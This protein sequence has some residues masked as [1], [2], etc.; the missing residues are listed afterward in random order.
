VVQA[1]DFPETKIRF[2][3]DAC[4]QRVGLSDLT[5]DEWIAH[6]G[7]FEPLPDN[8]P[9]PL[10][11][12]YHGHQFRAYN[13]DI[14]DGRGFTFAQLRD[15][16]ERLLDLG[17]KGSGQTPH[18]RFGDGR[19][20]LKGGVREILATEMLEAR[21]V[22]TSKTL[23]VIETGEQLQRN[24]EPSPTRSCVLVRL[25]HAHIRFGSFERHAHEQRPDR[26]RMLADHCIEHY[27]P[28]LEDRNP[29]E[30]YSRWFQ[31]VARRTI[32]LAGSWMIAGFVHGVLN[33]DNM[34]I[35]GESFDYG[36][37][38]FLPTY[39]PMFIAAYF[40]HGGLYAFGRQPEAVL[41][42]LLRFAE[43]IDSLTPVQQSIEWLEAEFDDV[44]TSAVLER[45]CD[46]LGISRGDTTE[47]L[48]LV[49][50]AFSFARDSQVGYD[51]FFFD[52]Y[53][54]SAS[55]ER[56]RRSPDAR[57]YEHASFRRVS[58][59]L[60]RHAPAPGAE[61]RLGDAPFDAERPESM[62]IEEV[63]AVW[64]A[65]DENDDWAPLHAKVAAIRRSPMLRDVLRT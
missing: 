29:K 56:A 41:W 48:D 63:E 60:D 49:D 27:Y 51:Q 39:D 14:G 44:L 62:L 58:Q 54:G 33:T 24:D 40:D 32:E 19:L 47:G 18:S 59:L 50:A 64:R 42:N 10:C 13:A 9:A 22:Y 65:I 61:D 46:R 57:A 11:M 6:F 35:C 23:S 16:D 21:G 45:F 7:R 15:A 30:R 2:R 31:A 38:R 37:W 43:A 34:N 52:W 1:A 36:P 3:N 20:T 17:T 25:G 12:R 5:P 55:A 4:A 53:G 26:V 8:L 28:A